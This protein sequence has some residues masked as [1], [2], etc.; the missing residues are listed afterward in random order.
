MTTELPAVMLLDVDG[1]LN[2]TRPKWP[3]PYRTS[4]LTDHSGITWP[5]RWSPQ[6]I[7]ELAALHS[8]GIAEIRW[9]SSYAPDADALNNLF[10]MPGI[11]GCWTDHVPSG[12]PLEIRKLTTALTVLE[13]RRRLVWIDDDAIPPGR[14]RRAAGL[15]GDALF[16]T[17]NYNVGLSP[18]DIRNI[19]KF[20][21]PGYMPP[22]SRPR[23]TRMNEQTRFN[24]STMIHSL[25][26]GG[27]DDPS[28]AIRLGITV[29][30][31]RGIRREYG[32]DAGEQRWTGRNTR[33]WRQLHAV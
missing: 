25:A 15:T 8:Y 17:P 26:A 33:T 28:I 21:I 19:K 4:P 11:P 1:V 12:K 29:A 3:G 27:T 2:I 32:I 18:G 30:Q 9:C 5:M 6:L 16:V 23:A 31:V 22:S 10:R 14:Q 24:L 13:E 20:L 7:T